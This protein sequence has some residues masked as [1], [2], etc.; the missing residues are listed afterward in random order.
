M[1]KTI[2]DLKESNLPME[3][4][5]DVLSR[6]CDYLLTDDNYND[7]YIQNQFKYANDI[8]QKKN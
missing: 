2:F 1:I 5:V 7:N 4:K 3:V 8:L 6:M